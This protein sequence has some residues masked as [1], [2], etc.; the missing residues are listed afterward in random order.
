MISNVNYILRNIILLYNI[1]KGTLVSI[2]I[3]YFS[4]LYRKHI[5]FGRTN[6]ESKKILIKIYFS[7]N[8]F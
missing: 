7:S 8:L 6:F 4:L 1:T 3:I 2:N 5:Y